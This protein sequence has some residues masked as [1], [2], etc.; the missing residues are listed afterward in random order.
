MAANTNA[1]I[2]AAI[3]NEI[4]KEHFIPRAK[5]TTTE[6]YTI[7]VG[8]GLD[9]SVLGQTTDE[10]GVITENWNFVEPITLDAENGYERTSLGTMDTPKN[11]QTQNSKI[12][13]F[14]ETRND[15]WGNVAYFGLFRTKDV[16]TEPT[17]FFWAKLTD[18]AGE[19]TT[20]QIPGEDSEGN[21]YIP[22]FRAEK[23]K[24]AIDRD[25]V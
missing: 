10:E 11:G 21:G 3:A 24:I 18:S 2:S 15:G 14:N 1:M 20:K 9:S 19:V 4:L 22:I 5:T 6:A 7:Y 17:P 8:L 23:L 12:I 13:Y 16:T 25:P